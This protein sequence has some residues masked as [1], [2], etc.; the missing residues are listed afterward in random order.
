MDTIALREY[1]YLPDHGHLHARR[2]PGGIE[3]GLPACNIQESRSGEPLPVHDAVRIEA[4][5]EDQA[6]RIARE[7]REMRAETGRRYPL[8]ALCGREWPSRWYATRSLG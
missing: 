4:R 8:P 6:L 7:I 2:D 3:I 5:D 1:Y